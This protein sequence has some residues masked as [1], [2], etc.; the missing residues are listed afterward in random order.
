M[1]RCKFLVPKYVRLPIILAT[2]LFSH[3]SI[4]TEMTSIWGNQYVGSTAFIS[5][6]PPLPRRDE[7]FTIN[8]SGVWRGSCFPSSGQLH[9]TVMKQRIVV[10]TSRGDNICSN[11]SDPQPFTRSAVIQ[12]AAWV[13][14]DDQKPLAIGLRIDTSL[15]TNYWWERRFE[16][17]WGL[18]EIPPRL[19]SGYWIGDEIPYQ[20]LMIQQQG[21][22][23]VFYEMNYSRTSGEPNW[24]YASAR[25]LGNSTNGVSY[26]IDWISPT[27]DRQVQPTREELNFDVGSAGIV[28]EGVNRIKAFYGWPGL[29]HDYKRFVFALD[30]GQLPATVPD[31]VGQWNL[32]GFNGQILNQTF[33]FEFR[34]GSKIDTNLYRFRSIDDE[35]VMDCQVNLDGEGNCALTNESLGL[36]MNYDLLDFNGNYGKGSLNSPDGVEPEQTGILIRPVFHLPA[37]D[38]Q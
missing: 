28:V 35:W 26:L 29:S 4:A 18:H 23:V 7:P 20:G 32:Y 24:Q 9:V 6:D 22:V 30:S 15:V 33:Q 34:V 10:S 14:I 36:V 25:F 21:D 2:L 13:D 37:L 11:K 27:T 19:E 1:N 5:L 8:V 16:L 3:F 17:S 12:S 38:L 31:M